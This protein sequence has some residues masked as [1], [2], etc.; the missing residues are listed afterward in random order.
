MGES[1]GSWEISV[2][3]AQFCCG[4]ETTSKNNV[5]L[6]GGAG[7][8]CWDGK[9]ER[10]R[11]HDMLV[12]PPARGPRLPGKTS[13]VSSQPCHGLQLRAFLTDTGTETSRHS[14]WCTRVEV[15]ETPVQIPFL[16]LCYCVI[17]GATSPLSLNFSSCKMEPMDRPARLSRDRKQNRS[18]SA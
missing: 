15:R 6:K 9:I 8:E 18:G 17:L 4:L 3:F 14:G 13:P 5:Y 12:L 11:V 16:L 1:E 2:P 7:E 10:P